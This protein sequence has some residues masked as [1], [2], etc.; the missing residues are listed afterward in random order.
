MADLESENLLE[1][2]IDEQFY[3][4]DADNNVGTFTSSISSRLDLNSTG[5]KRRYSNRK[6]NG[7][8]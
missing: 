4:L 6:G 5:N 8:I 7:V 3:C 1:L 2:C